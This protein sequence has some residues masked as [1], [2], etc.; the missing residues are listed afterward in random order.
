VDAPAVEP[1]EL[2]AEAERR[3]GRSLSAGER[4]LDL[5]GIDR[6]V[7]GG[8]DSLEN[9]IEAEKMRAA[10]A[11]LRGRGSRVRRQVCGR[12]LAGKNPLGRVSNPEAAVRLTK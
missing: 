12:T 3:L 8:K 11:W 6:D 2:F 4:A 7:E 1:E 5:A 10:R 9:A